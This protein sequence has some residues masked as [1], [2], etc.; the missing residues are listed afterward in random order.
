MIIFSV[1]LKI[2]LIFQE[3]RHLIRVRLCK[4]AR[5]EVS[6]L[7]GEKRSISKKIIQ[8]Q[9]EIYTDLVVSGT[10]TYQICVEV[11]TVSLLHNEA[12]CFIVPFSTIKVTHKKYSNHFSKPSLQNNDL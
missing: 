3:T 1:D 11:Y 8:Q 9:V 7:E 2:P 12:C 4:I 10:Q 5:L 6:H